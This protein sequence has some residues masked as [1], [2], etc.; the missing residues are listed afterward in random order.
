MATVEPAG[1]RG[2]RARA[3]KVSGDSTPRHVHGPE[4]LAELLRPASTR[5]ERPRGGERARAA[6]E[7]G[8]GAPLRGSGAGPAL[9]VLP[10][11]SRHANTRGDRT[12]VA[13]QAAAAEPLLPV[14]SS[15][16]P[17]EDEEE[18]LGTFVTRS[19][20]RKPGES[21]PTR[22]RGPGVLREAPGAASKL[23]ER[24]RTARRSGVGSRQQPPS[25]GVLEE[26]AGPDEGARPEVV[27]E[28]ASAREGPARDAEHNTDVFP[29]LGAGAL[30]EA[31]EPASSRGLR[32]R[33]AKE[34]PADGT[35]LLPPGPEAVEEGMV[36]TST[37]RERPRV[38]MASPAVGTPLMPASGAHLGE[39]PKPARTHVDRSRLAKS[40]PA[41]GT[42]VLQP[43][44]LA[45]GQATGLASGRGERSR[46]LRQSADGTPLS[47][48]VSRI[49]RETPGL[50][51]ARGERFRAA[52][53]HSDASPL[54]ESGSALRSSRSTLRPA[55]PEPEFMAP[56]AVPVSAP[57]PEDLQLTEMKPPS[58][59]T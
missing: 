42:P 38:A 51:S 25:S 50:H 59:P 21:V 49:L 46:G 33:V 45:Q 29:L 41:D 58:S 54:P 20:T 22:P 30:E 56:V 9:V 47:A 32:S 53:K 44:S 43:D 17:E 40:S 31:P 39:P 18:S 27:M 4:T 36:P 11:G 12:R 14:A 34:S 55:K 19:R 26:G 24:A 8:D 13:K 52:R 10:E 5:G 57:E 23:G 6:R 37:R 1:T 7:S 2:E 3:A 16:V 15:Y 28:P 35:P 48:P